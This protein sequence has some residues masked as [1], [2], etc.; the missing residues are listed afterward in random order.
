MA[1]KVSSRPPA[2]AEEEGGDAGVPATPRMAMHP[3]ESVE[4]APANSCGSPEGDS[5]AFRGLD[6]PLAEVLGSANVT[7]ELT[8]VLSGSPVNSLDEFF[9][10]VNSLYEFFYPPR[11]SSTLLIL[12]VLFSPSLFTRI[13]P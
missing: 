9:Y 11:S 3:S 8:A 7:A 2:G 4:G 5:L 10:S 6:D 1:A 13:R 12:L